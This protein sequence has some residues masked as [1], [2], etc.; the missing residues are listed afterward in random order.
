MAYRRKV[1]SWFCV[2]FYP[3]KTI[4]TLD[5]VWVYIKM[6]KT[7]PGAWLILFEAQSLSPLQSSFTNWRKPYTF[8]SS[9]ISVTVDSST[10]ICFFFCF[11]W[12]FQVFH[13]FCL[14]SGSTE[15]AVNTWWRERRNSV[16]SK[17][18]SSDWE[19]NFDRW[20]AKGV[21]KVARRSEVNT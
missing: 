20:R 2:L 19:F 7:N 3:S 17:I 16:N 10:R 9:N 6:R 14:H 21:G 8:C 4:V 13:T 12:H 1:F 5:E 15:S 11:F 18:Y